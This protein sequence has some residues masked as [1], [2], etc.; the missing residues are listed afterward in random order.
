M[1]RRGA[2]A[3]GHPSL[4]RTLLAWLIV[5]LLVLVPLAAAMVYGLAVRP[6]LDGLDRALTGTAVALTGLIE[7]R[8]G[9][10]VLPISDQTA[11]ALRA[12]LV[13]EVAFAVADE[14][15]RLLGGDAA[16]LPL[17]PSV[18]A[19]QWRFF[20]A[21]LRG[22]GWRVAAY[23]AAC[24]APP[25]VCPVIVAES[26]GKRR[27]AERAVA[28]AALGAALLIALSLA[29]LAL[30]AVQRGLRPLREAAQEIEQRSLQRLGPIDVAALPSEV[31]SFG[32]AIND[33]FTR[34]REAAAAQRSFVADASHQLRT[35]LATLLSESARALAQPHPPALRPTLERLHAAAGRGARLAQQLLTLARA[36]EEALGTAVP[37]DVVELAELAAGCADDWLRPSLAAG[38]DLGFDLQPVRVPGN[39]LLLRELIGNLIH[40]AIQHAGPGARVTVHV[41]AAGALAV[42]EVEDDGHG[43]PEDELARVWDRFHRG[44]GAGGL[45]SGLGLAIVRDIARLHGGQARMQRGAGGKGVVVTVELPAAN[46][47]PTCPT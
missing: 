17:A 29:L 11:R 25:R 28:V 22:H 33:L 45:G 19:G 6:A 4:R 12:D 44:Q 3:R 43:L 36:E 40:N 15:G 10:P 38:Q 13:D 23:G 8:D 39:A 1:S 7:Q 2:A 26:L 5:P 41:R 32:V 24:G 20:D 21:E 47:S 30:L 9:R 14:R 27:G 31:A 42:I 18:P 46:L 37:Q 35:P 34:L 16:L